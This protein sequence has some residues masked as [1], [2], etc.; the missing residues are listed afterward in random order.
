MTAEQIEKLREELAKAENETLG[1][2][3]DYQDAKFTGMWAAQ[4]FEEYQIQEKLAIELRTRLHE[5][6]PTTDLWWE[7]P[8]EKPAA[9]KEFPVY[10][11]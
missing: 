2:W 1:L 4:L 6:D 5:V 8:E 10:Q 3:E 11:F 7:K 9:S